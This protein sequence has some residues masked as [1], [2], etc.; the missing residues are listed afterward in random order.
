MEGIGS[1]KSEFLTADV[2]VVGLSAEL[3]WEFREAVVDIHV[4]AVVH[5]ALLVRWLEGAAVGRAVESEKLVEAVT[6]AAEGAM[7]AVD[8]AVRPTGFATVLLGSAND[9]LRDFGDTIQNVPDCATQF[10]GGCVLGAWRSLDI[11][12]CKSGKG[13]QGGSC[14]K[15]FFHAWK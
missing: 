11:R 8:C 1:R 14:E 2:T 15:E 12:G 13:D 7:R 3:R 9:H 6:E 5:S 4:D 10:A